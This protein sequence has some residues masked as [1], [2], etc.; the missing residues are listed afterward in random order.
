MRSYTLDSNVIIN[1]KN[2]Y[3]R[4]VFPTF[5]ENLELLIEQELVCICRY[6]QIELQRGHDDLIVWVKDQHDFVCEPSEEELI[7]AS[8]I[9][10]LYPG[11]VRESENA[12]DP[13]IVAHAQVN[14][15]VIVSD[16]NHA[17]SHVAPQ[18]QKLPNVAN[19]QGVE[20]IRLLPFAREMQWSF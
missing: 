6:V 8:E 13:F 4:D 11:W 14:T 2:Q 17:S 3:P 1:L 12:A 16:E 10:N 20:S 7:L 18:N 9:S 15:H 19:A 5:W